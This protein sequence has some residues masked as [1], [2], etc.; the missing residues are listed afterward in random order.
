[1]NYTNNNNNNNNEGAT[2]I[3]VNELFDMIKFHG[4]E[5]RPD[6]RR[7]TPE[8]YNLRHRDRFK[9][10]K[11][12]MKYFQ[13][14]FSP[15]VPTKDVINKIKKYIGNDKVLGLYSGLGLWDYLLYQTGIQIVP[16]N[17]VVVEGIPFIPVQQLNPLDAIVRYE[18]DVL[19]IVWPLNFYNYDILFNV[20]Q[21]YQGSSIILV[22]DINNA[23]EIF[24]I[25]PYTT[26]FKWSLI[27]EWYLPQWV[28]TDYRVFIIEKVEAYQ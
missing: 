18:S 14:H 11:Q 27:T 3:P 22:A 4:P 20:L 17:N 6:M 16:T 24:N 8:D 13:N 28:G 21:Q 25:L 9:W 2:I 23:K 7:S 12:R 15:A 1:M 10:E 5:L 26:R 19:F